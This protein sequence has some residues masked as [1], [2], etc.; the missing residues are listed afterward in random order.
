MVPLL[1]PITCFLIDVRCCLA[2]QATIKFTGHTCNAAGLPGLRE[3][4]DHG[5]LDDLTGG[6]VYSAS[7]VCG[8][9]SIY[10]SCEKGSSQLLTK[11]RKTRICIPNATGL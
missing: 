9:R 1:L 8:T 6:H 5:D 3:A 2:S 7:G 11:T 4:D 10:G